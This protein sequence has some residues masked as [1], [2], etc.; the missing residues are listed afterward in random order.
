VLIILDGEIC[1]AGVIINTVFVFVI[2]MGLKVPEW[3]LNEIPSSLK[4]KVA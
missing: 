4:M 2:W 3:F 1:Y